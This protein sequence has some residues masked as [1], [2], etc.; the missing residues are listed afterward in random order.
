[1]QTSKSFIA[2]S[3]ATI[4]SYFQPIQSILT[5][6]LWLFVLNFLFGLVAGIVANKENF[7]FR[8]A[9]TCIS[10]VSVFL[11]I[12]STIF[13]IG[14]HLGARGGAMQAISTITYALLYFYS[15][16]ILKNLKLLFPASKGLIWIYNL[17][18]IELIAKLPR[19]NKIFSTMDSMPDANTDHRNQT[20]PNS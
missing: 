12:L 15:V 18:S 19:L 6:I 3:L 20:Q 10:E 13:F 4:L 14:D 17:L 1:M 11:V 9:F 16:N 5:A 2:V 7:S 8:K